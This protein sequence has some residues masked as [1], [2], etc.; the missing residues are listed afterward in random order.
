MYQPVLPWDY[1]IKAGTTKKVRGQKFVNSPFKGR[2]NWDYFS[3]W[4][5]VSTRL[6][7]GIKGRSWRS[8]RMACD[9][10]MNPG[11]Y[12][13]EAGIKPWSQGRGQKLVRSLYCKVEPR[14]K[15]WMQRLVARDILL[16]QGRSLMKPG[17]TRQN[18]II[19]QR[20]GTREACTTRQNL[21]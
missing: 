17:I 10:R 9:T 3:Q 21:R 16:L 15:S 5:K 6:E 14:I 20:L 7:P 8:Q 18:L 1:K 12:K 2:K 13:L 4:I 11:D 19:S